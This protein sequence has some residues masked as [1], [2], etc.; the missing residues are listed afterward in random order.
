MDST[1]DGQEPKRL[2]KGDMSRFAIVPTAWL[3]DPALTSSEK[4]V[5]AVLASYADEQGYCWPAIRTVA[6]DSGLSERQVQYS[7]KR[8]KEIGALEIARRT[9]AEGAS[10]S[11]GFWM[12]GYDRKVAGGVQEVHQGGAE[13]APGGVHMVHPNSTSM[14][15]TKGTATTTTAAFA[16][17]DPDQ[18]RVYEAYRR[19]S[20]LPEAFDASLRTLLTPMTGGQ[21]CTLEQ[22]GAALLELAGNGEAFNLARLRGYVRKAEQGPAA[23]PPYSPR[24]RAQGDLY[25]EAARLLGISARELAS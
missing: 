16:F 12:L 9:D 5:L 2:E 15:S 7:L 10:T 19:G 17:N 11:N 14:N 24:G 20:R 21:P 6:R 4:L 23:T 8:L 25:A 18:Q 13:A 22:L 3:R 1:L